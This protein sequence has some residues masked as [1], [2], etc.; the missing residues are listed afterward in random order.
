MIELS[1]GHLLILIMALVFNAYI[2]WTGFKTGSVRLFWG[3]KGIGIIQMDEHP[4][5]YRAYLTGIALSIIIMS[6]LIL[7]FW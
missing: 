6:A 5:L 1:D 3:L 2:L 7:S 4:I